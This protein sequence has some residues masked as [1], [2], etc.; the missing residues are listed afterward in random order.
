[1]ADLTLTPPALAQL[2]GCRLGYKRYLASSRYRQAMNCWIAQGET[3]K[4]SLSMQRVRA[5]PAR[6]R[7]GALAD[8]TS[9]SNPQI[10]PGISQTATFR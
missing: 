2:T 9:R 4:D 10:A 1:M 6:T 7:A 5:K 8:A 3:A